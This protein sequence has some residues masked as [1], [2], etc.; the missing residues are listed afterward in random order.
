M[1]DAEGRH[2]PIVLPAVA[3]LVL[4]GVPVKFIGLGAGLIHRLLGAET[5]A[6]GVAEEH[7]EGVH[8]HYRHVELFRPTHV[9]AVDPGARGLEQG[10][11]RAAE[12]REGKFAGTVS[13][14]SE[15]EEQVG[16][17]LSALQDHRRSI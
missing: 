11:G 14:K 5:L 17:I 12:G 16:E 6:G 4:E 3:L 15:G 2:F 9:L 13:V 1:G 10:G 7:L 8:P